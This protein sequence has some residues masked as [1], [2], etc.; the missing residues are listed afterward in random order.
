MPLAYAY[1]VMECNACGN[2]ANFRARSDG[3][4]F[5]WWCHDC[6]QF[7][8]QEHERVAH[9]IEDPVICCKCHVLHATCRVHTTLFWQD[10][11][12]TTYLCQLCYERHDDH[13]PHHVCDLDSTSDSP[14]DE[15]VGAAPYEEEVESRYEEEVESPFQEDAEH[16][17]E[18]VAVS[19]SSWQIQ[20]VARSESSWHIEDDCSS[21]KS[22][23]L[24]WHQVD[25]DAESD[26]SSQCSCMM[27]TPGSLPAESLHTHQQCDAATDAAAT[28][29][30]VST[31]NNLGAGQDQ[32]QGQMHTILALHDQPACTSIAGACTSIAGT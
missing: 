17:C 9:D 2:K 1:Q 4:A 26:A 20:D 28:E 8:F 31:S 16:H 23:N 21:T 27:V 5:Q 29:D 10:G 14:S 18:D 3:E 25:A 7:C 30:A 11:S 15:D 19:E 24:T 13:Q 12:N 32:Q 6:Y 22:V